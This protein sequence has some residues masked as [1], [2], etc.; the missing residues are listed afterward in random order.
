MVFHDSNLERMTGDT[1]ELEEVDYAE[2]RDLK[3]GGTDYQI[4]TLREV[5]DLVDGQVPIMIE[6]K[7]S[8]KVME[9]GKLV[10]EEVKD[11]DGDFSILSFQPFIL[12][13]YKE[14]APEIVRGQLSGGVSEEESLKW[15]E[16]LVLTNF[17]VNFISKPQYIAHAV[18]ELDHFRIPSLRASGIPVITWTITEEAMFESTLEK[19]DSIIFDSVPSMYE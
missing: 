4:P 10:Y 11:Y 1:R 7:N 13:W 18:E 9:L 6:L 15:Y 17:M 8:S 12:K 16:R 2:L 3:V 19:S 5:L 14:N